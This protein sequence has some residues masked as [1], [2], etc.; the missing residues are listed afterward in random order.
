LTF[1]LGTDRGRLEAWAISLALALALPGGAQYLPSRPHE[2]PQKQRVGQHADDMDGDA[3][4]DSSQQQ[5]RLRAWNNQRQKSLVSDTEKL[6]QLA[7][8][9]DIEVKGDNPGKLTQAE[10]R[11]LAEIEKLAHKVKEKMSYTL[12]GAATQPATPYQF[13]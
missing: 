6:L 12:P 8:R 2:V 7:T 3:A 10:E 11:E 13:P 4:G 5:Q 9:L 1:G